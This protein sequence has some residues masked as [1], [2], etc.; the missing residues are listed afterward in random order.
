[1]ASLTSESSTVA[2]SALSRSG[3]NIT[4]R[5]KRCRALHEA[6]AHGHAPVIEELL[7]DSRIDP[8][9]DDC[10]SL[11][12]A[13]S[14]GHAAAVQ[15]FIADG[16]AYPGACDDEALQSA[17]AG[18]HTAVVK[19]LLASDRVDPAACNNEPLVLACRHGHPAVVTLLLAKPL[20]DPTARHNAA[21]LAASRHGHAEVVCMLLADPRVDPTEDDCAALTA[22]VSSVQVASMSKLLSDSRIDA[23]VGP[24]L[25]EPALAVAIQAADFALVKRMLLDPRSDAAV[26]EG[27]ALVA[28]AQGSSYEMLQLLLADERDGDGTMSERMGWALEDAAIVN[29]AVIAGR[30]LADPRFQ[31]DDVVL[32][33]ESIFRRFN[34]DEKIAMHAAVVK[35]LITDPRIGP[36]NRKSCGVLVAAACGDAE[37]LQ[38]LL[39]LREGVP[40]VSNLQAVVQAAQHGH[41]AALRLLLKEFSIDIPTGV[42][43]DARR[44]L[45][46]AVEH[47]HLEVVEALLAD[48][49]GRFV[50]FSVCNESA[51][52]TAAE[53]GHVAILDR[54]LA[55]P[56]GDPRPAR[57]HSRNTGALYAAV[58]NGHVAVVER[59]LRDPRVDPTR[60]DSCIVYQ[61]ATRGHV[62][63]VALLLAQPGVDAFAAQ[64]GRLV[65][66]C[67]EGDLDQVNTLLADPRIDPSVRDDAPLRGA[68][69]AGRTAVVERLLSLPCVNVNTHCGD[70]WMQVAEGGHA[71]VLRLMLADPRAETKHMTLALRTAVGENKLEPLRVLLEDEGAARQVAKLNLLDSS[72]KGHWGI[73]NLLLQHDDSLLNGKLEGV[74][75][76]VRSHLVTKKGDD[77]I[78]LAPLLS[79]VMHSLPSLTP[80]LAASLRRG[81][82]AVELSAAAW[83]RRRAAV[84]AWM[85]SD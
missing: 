16:R 72:S 38:V 33:A 45:A 73:V 80:A 74:R 3:R 61:A 70:L 6:S 2:G 21:L 41:A 68:V 34:T 32:A 11:R 81:T 31:D 8:A 76:C 9:A 15:C 36:G 28:A 83:R 42:Y 55:D 71:E 52:S 29:N 53:H 57:D 65:Y 85:Y 69:A 51:V 56:R 59:L 24:E 30:L 14:N 22:A 19:L 25:F 64:Q 17:C 46:D 35:V 37:L 62:D 23:A 26:A 7:A 5:V 77:S 78:F 50:P 63:I 48:P 12:A 43:G 27:T 44:I 66:A 20:V 10:A 39:A 18:G 49:Q 13:A 47:G 75:Q 84:F 4:E 60:L 67:E 82:D 58:A 54:L 1:M 40:S 79:F